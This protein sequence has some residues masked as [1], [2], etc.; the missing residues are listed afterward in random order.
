MLTVFGLNRVFDTYIGCS[1]CTFSRYI[2]SVFTL[3]IVFYVTE[4]P[5][6]GLNYMVRFIIR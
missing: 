6:T 5:I 2:L 3:I 1:I 4:T